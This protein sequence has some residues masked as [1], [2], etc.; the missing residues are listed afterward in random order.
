MKMAKKNGS[1][2]ELVKSGLEAF[3]DLVPTADSF[4]TPVTADLL[5]GIAIER[6]VKLEPGQ[7]VVG[8]YLGLGAHVEINDAV[9]GEVRDLPTHR[10][11]VRPNVV[12]R[13]IESYQLKMELPRLID[14]RVR[15]ILLG[16]QET[17]GGRRVNDFIVAPELNQGPIDVEPAA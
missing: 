16:K 5:Q 14:K 2:T 9:T 13:L 10:I 15:V 6:L 17:R 4:I 11:E 1:E 8:K 3:T 7:A 12:V